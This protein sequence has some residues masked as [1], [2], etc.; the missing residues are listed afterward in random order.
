MRRSW[1]KYDNSQTKK[2][3]T[4]FLV[5][6][7]GARLLGGNESD[8]EKSFIG[9][10]CFRNNLNDDPANSTFYILNI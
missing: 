9:K 8:V 7:Q 1:E 4:A 5:D 3:R 6:K 2:F 10:N